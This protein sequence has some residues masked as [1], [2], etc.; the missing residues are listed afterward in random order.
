MTPHAARVQ[1]GT[2]HGRAP[3]AGIP[4]AAS[5]AH[6]PEDAAAPLAAG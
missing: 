1:L 3:L 2:E 4:R 5:P 6:Q